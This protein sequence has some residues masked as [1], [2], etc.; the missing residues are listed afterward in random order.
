V[1]SA[2]DRIERHVWLICA[3]V[4]LGFA[5][6]ILDTTIVNVAL[7]TLGRELH[8]S[9]SQIQWVVTGYMLSLAA[10]IP[11]TGWAA[12]RF[13]TRRMYLIS[14]IL[15]TAGSMLCGIS[16]T[17]TE[18]VI[19]RVLQGIGGGMIMPL[20]MML[21]AHAA[22]PKQ[23]GRVMSVTMMP[24]MLAPILG[25]TIGGLIIDNASWR[26]IFYVNVPVGVAAVIAAVKLLPPADQRS[27]RAL[28]F[29]GLALMAV[30]LPLVTYGLA[31]V[32]T[33]GGFSSAKVI[34]PI[35]AGLVLVAAFVRHA[36]RV[37]NPLLNLHLYRRPTFSTAS[38]ATF[39]LG[40]AL[41]GGM[42]LMPL[43]WQHVRHQSPLDA[44]LLL[45]P[46]GLGM[47]LV[48][49]AVGR[50]TD[51]LGGGPPALWGVSVTTLATIPFGLIGAHTSIV[52]LSVALFIRGTGIGFAFM[53]AM[54]A[55]FATLDKSEIPDASPQLNVVQRVG[56]SLGT[57]VLAVVLQRATAGAHSLGAAA[58][59]F[60][61]A[62][63]ASIA[64]TAVAVIPA[65][66]LLRAERAARAEHPEIAEMEREALL[67][68]VAA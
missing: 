64:L 8:S 7:A 14:I 35:V 42:I 46:Q 20:G 12:E 15:F 34:F 3:V 58:S 62:F 9:I 51:R 39:F 22:G 53:P 26:W 41:F 45:A 32:G 68:G 37:P 19:F 43:Y 63:W 54:T 21:M 28:D 18:L 4:I 1:A 48:M 29:R 6:S 67:E 50:L 24:L 13:G 40:A 44:G 11:M 33:T 61:T 30:G 31:E 25:P 16:T 10:V 38:L 17:T 36:L 23:M 5:M 66:I 49:P 56:G 55:A 65:V 2:N 59:G 52:W 60:G 57:A 27:E 47:L